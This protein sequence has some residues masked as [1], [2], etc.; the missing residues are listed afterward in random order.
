MAQSDEQ[1]IE[2]S[3]ALNEYVAASDA[4]NAV[5]GGGAE[6]ADRISELKVPADYKEMVET[7]RRAANRYA[8]ALDAVGSGAPVGLREE[9]EQA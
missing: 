8:D 4:L 6:L 1:Q 7:F 2:L 3:E 5:H 9:V